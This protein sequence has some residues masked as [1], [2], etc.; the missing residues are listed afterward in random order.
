M[1]TSVKRGGGGWGW[2]GVLAAVPPLCIVAAGLS[3]LG[4]KG[5]A[6][7]SLLAVLR[8]WDA[9][10]L[11][12]EPALPLSRP[13]RRVDPRPLHAQ[14]AIM[15][16]DLDA[17][18]TTDGGRLFLIATPPLPVGDVCLWQGVFAAEAALRE[19]QE[20]GRRN[21]LRARKALEG[22]ALLSSKGRP[23]VRAVYPAALKT[24]PPGRW[25]HRDARWQWKEDA[26]VD[27]AVGWVFGVTMVRELVPELR[28][29]AD[30]L[31]VRYAEVLRAGGYRLRNSDGSLTRF[32][33]VGGAFVDSP[34][35]MLSTLAVLAQ[36]ARAD[37]SGPWEAD[38]ARFL[39]QAQ[40]RWGAYASGPVLWRNETTNHDIAFLALAAALLTEQEPAVRTV[41]ARGLV[42][43]SR[44][45]AKMGDS[46]WIYLSLWALDRAG[47]GDPRGDEE[48]A[49]WMARRR[50]LLA[51]AKVA[52]LEW[53]YPR[54]KVKR[55]VVNS[56][57]EDIPM[58]RWPLW[59]PRVP[60]QPLPVWQR[61]PAD[62]VW[63]RSAYALDD[64][65]GYRGDPPQ[66]FSPLDF[67]AAYRLGL[68][69]GGLRPS[70]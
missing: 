5:L 35:G 56:E 39:A 46:F 55:E 48:V 43:L 70:E 32:N 44:L 19:A 28:G 14:A 47:C 21:L 54:C 36:A 49:S 25:Y 11:A 15:E 27:S 12:L 23:I 62:F 38:R 6:S 67:L 69:V 31:L 53:D 9:F 33:A 3:P 17:D 64:W 18:F 26:S 40:D 24:E 4:L 1:R 61:P 65:V 16:R 30:A 29:P 13:A 20:P 10:H 8:S 37:P 42:H 68:A 2:L 22:L 34:A 50:Q 7:E 60:R 57:R 66:R 59:G 63:Q 41:Y 45:T 51:E 58:R 52:M